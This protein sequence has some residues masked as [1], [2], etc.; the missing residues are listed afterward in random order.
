MNEYP[1][2]IRN[3]MVNTNPYEKSYNIE[4]TSLPEVDKRYALQRESSH[5]IRNVIITA[6][7]VAS[8]LGFVAGWSYMQSQNMDKA[9][10]VVSTE[11]LPMGIV[12]NITENPDF[13]YFT[14]QNGDTFSKYE[15]IEARKLAENYSTQNVGK[16]M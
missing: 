16:Q 2:S 13:S 1:N 7:L 5:K 3:N 11:V 6:A 15:G 4:I 10:T 12:L 14:N 9:T 8:A